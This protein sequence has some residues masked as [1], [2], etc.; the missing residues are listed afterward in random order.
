MGK[1]G[2]RSLFV[3]TYRKSHKKTTCATNQPSTHHMVNYGVPMPAVAVK[4]PARRN[5]TAIGLLVVIGMASLALMHEVI[6]SRF[7]CP[8]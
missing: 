5:L 2:L 4:A 7:L 1:N 6:T 3:F 8:C